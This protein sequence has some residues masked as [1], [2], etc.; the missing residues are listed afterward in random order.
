MT[1]AASR[2]NVFLS[3]EDINFMVPRNRNDIAWE[4]ISML[5]TTIMGYPS[6]IE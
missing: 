1:L 2:E 5:P 4:D 6:M 3:W